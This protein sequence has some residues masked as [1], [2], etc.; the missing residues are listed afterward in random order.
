MTLPSFIVSHFEFGFDIL[1]LLGCVHM[2]YKEGVEVKG[3]V[4][5]FSL[6]L[7]GPQESNSGCSRNLYLI[8][9]TLI[10]LLETFPCKLKIKSWTVFYSQK[11]TRIIHTRFIGHRVDLLVILCNLYSPKCLPFYLPFLFALQT[12]GFGDPP[13]KYLPLEMLSQQQTCSC[14]VYM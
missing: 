4:E 12:L 8:S 10:S 13:L 9:L 11:R 5:D 6:S 3:Q 2:F 7:S 14:L 1:H